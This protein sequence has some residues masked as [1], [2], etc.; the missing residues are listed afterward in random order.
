LGALAGGQHGRVFDRRGREL[1]GSAT[2]PGS[3]TLPT[4]SPRNEKILEYPPLGH[5]RKKLE[6]RSDGAA[7]IS[8]E[9]I[10]QGF[11]AMSF[12]TVRRRSIAALEDR[13]RFWPRVR[14]GNGPIES[15]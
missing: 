3:F 2:A 1:N 11:T 14:T 9:W 6:S 10:A 13:F 7:V 4:T 12:W 8:F 15:E 5:V